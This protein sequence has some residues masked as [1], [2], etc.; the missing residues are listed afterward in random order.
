MIIWSVAP[1]V[2]RKIAEDFACRVMPDV[3]GQI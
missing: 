2:W 3:A 1:E